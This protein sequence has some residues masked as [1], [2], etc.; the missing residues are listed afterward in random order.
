[1]LFEQVGLVEHDHNLFAPLL[2][3]RQEGALALGEGPL[4]R[5]DEQHQVGAG[6][7]VA[8]Q[9]LV[10][11]N[12]RVGA[13]R[14]DDRQLAQH[15]GGETACEQKPLQRLLGRHVAVTQQG[16]PV[17]RRRDAL[18][19][20]LLAQ[21]RV[22]EA[23]LPGVELARDHQQEQLVEVRDRLIER[24]HIAGRDIGAE[25]FQRRAQLL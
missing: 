8:R 1:M 20:H 18:G 7:E 15:I 14:I 4:G 5:G 25:E 6:D 22:D 19:Q 16:D 2:D 23:G 17:G 9:L 21:Q 13:G 24:T 11:A 10:A 3:R 12:D